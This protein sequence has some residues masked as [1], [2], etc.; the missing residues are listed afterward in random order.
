MVGGSH[1]EEEELEDEELED[2]ELEDEE[3]ED[4][5]PPSCP[6]AGLA[7]ARSTSISRPTRREG[8]THTPGL[9]C[10]SKNPHMIVVILDARSLAKT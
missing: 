1:F 10:L 5:L 4:E 6:S 2:E 7:A 3:L 8:R 9:D